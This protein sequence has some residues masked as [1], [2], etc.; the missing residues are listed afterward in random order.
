MKIKR[1]LSI[2]IMLIIGFVMQTTIF[3]Y[4]ELANV[5][6]NILLIITSVSGFMF[7]I[8]YGMLAGGVSGLLMDLMYS[9]LIGLSIIIYFFIGYF[10]VIVK[11][12]Y[13][14]DDLSIPLALIGISDFVYGMLFYI[15]SF[16]LR[17]RLALFAYLKQVMLPEVVYTVIIGLFIY[18]FVHWLDSKLYPPVD[19][20]LE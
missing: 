5:R 20:P 14:K 15:M 19:V 8:R 16:M 10:N 11:K 1:Y 3:G 2:V 6:P 12:F 9:D 13:F 17:G 7:G 18:K 4:L